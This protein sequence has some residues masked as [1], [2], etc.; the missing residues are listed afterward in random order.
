MLRFRGIEMIY[1]V[2]VRQRKVVI[3]CLESPS[4]VNI[5]VIIVRVQ[6]ARSNALQEYLLV[7]VNLCEKQ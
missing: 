5:V 2:P 3:H 6:I 7:P 4:I 1:I